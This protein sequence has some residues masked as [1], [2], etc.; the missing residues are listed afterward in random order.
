MGWGGRDR[1][2]VKILVKRGFFIDT[3]VQILVII[4]LKH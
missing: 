2:E 1:F 4:G 3:T